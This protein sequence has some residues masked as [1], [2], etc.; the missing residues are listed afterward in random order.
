ML[1][2]LCYCFLRLYVTYY[3]FFLPIVF[4]YTPFH[5]Q[6]WHFVALLLQNVGLI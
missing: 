3:G 6:L 4:L 5:V 1:Q 2:S